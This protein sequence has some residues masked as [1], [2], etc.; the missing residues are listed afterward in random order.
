MSDEPMGLGASIRCVMDAEYRR[1]QGDAGLTRQQ[2]DDLRL[3]L[4]TAKANLIEMYANCSPF[5]EGHA[6]LQGKA[7]GI[8]LALSYLEE[9]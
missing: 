6:R 3:R 8:G 7:Q 4:N 5:T 2:L 9:Y 1:G